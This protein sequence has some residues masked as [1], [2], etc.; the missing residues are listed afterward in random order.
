MW[1]SINFSSMNIHGVMAPCE[2]GW[3]LLAGKFCVSQA[4]CATA[5]YKAV[6]EN[7][8]HGVQS[9]HTRTRTQS[10]VCFIS[11]HANQG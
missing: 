3:T 5:I 6:K 2:R 7:R 4:M 9:S 8:G 11:K 10:S 1:F